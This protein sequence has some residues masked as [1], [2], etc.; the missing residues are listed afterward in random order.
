MG[1]VQAMAAGDLEIGGNRGTLTTIASG[2]E[3]R[4]TAPANRRPRQ[5][6]RQG[7]RAFNGTGAQTVFN[8]PHGLTDDAGAG[9]IPT[10]ADA[11]GKD[12]VSNAAKTVTWDATNIIVTYTA[13]PAS[14]T[15]NV[16]LGWVA[17][18]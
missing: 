18:R 5:P 15:N 4:A 16:N 9:V 11:N 3:G 10:Y 13:A 8:I 6:I 17:V 1:E 2:W 14:G 12:A 7:T